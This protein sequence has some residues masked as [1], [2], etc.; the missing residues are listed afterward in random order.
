MNQKDHKAIAEIIQGTTFLGLRSNSD[1]SYDEVDKIVRRL[2]KSI[3]KEIA[4]QLADYFEK[5][6]S[7]VC[8]G[9]GYHLG[10]DKRQFL[11]DCGVR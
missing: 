11:K 5:E 2:N 3:R 10:F 1:F 9:C 4:I 8:G 7:D 6:Y